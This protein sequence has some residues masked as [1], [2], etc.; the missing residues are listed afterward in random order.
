MGHVLAAADRSADDTYLWSAIQF[1]ADRLPDNDPDS[2]AFSRVLR[3]KA[4]IAN[5][6]DAVVTGNQEQAR[7]QQADEAQL[8]LKLI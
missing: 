2:I 4:G 6:A 7:K 8:Q 1:L 3:T 5:A